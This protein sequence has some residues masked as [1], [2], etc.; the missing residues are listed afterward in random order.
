MRRWVPLFIVAVIIVLALTPWG[1]LFFPKK[2][3]LF[4]IDITDF[5]KRTEVFSS[6]INKLLPEPQAS[7]LNGILWGEKRKMPKSFYNDLIRTGTLHIIA[8]S[9]MNITILVSLLGKITL[10][11]GRRKSVIISM[12]GI[13]L[14]ILFVGGSPSVIR[15]GI[16]GGMSLMAVYWGR[17]TWGLLSL[18]LTGVV[19]IIANPTWLREISFQLS[20]LATLGIILL[21]GSGEGTRRKG[22][23]EEFIYEGRE[24]LRTTL[25]A[26]VFTLPVI[27]YNFKQLSLISPL[28]NVLVLWIVPPIM[29]LGF[30]L[31][32]VSLV[33]LELA[34]PLSWIVWVPLSYFIEIVKLTANL[35]L[36][37]VSF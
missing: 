22:W 4:F 6:R 11:L 26:Q 10:F 29:A 19:M 15:A 31:S 16:M 34:T 36:A 12:L 30:I 18:W 20:F 17:K 8:L 5:G 24:N 1:N 37:Q 2:L 32:C 3:P 21:G 27:L 28:T 9:G 7:L 13:F 23:F 35:P 33:S 25:A 14:F